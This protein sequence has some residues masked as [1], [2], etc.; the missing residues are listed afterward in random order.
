MAMSLL[1]NIAVHQ[2][3]RSLKPQ[4]ASKMAT[5]LGPISMLA[6]DWDLPATKLWPCLPTK[7]IG[8]PELVIREELC[9]RW[10]GGGQS[11]INDLEKWQ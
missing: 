5:S 3:A 2:H 6:L 8:L 4:R 1:E 10:H 7:K 9:V 11:L